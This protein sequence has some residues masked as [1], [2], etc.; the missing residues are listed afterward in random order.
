M[1]KNN[2][3]PIHNGLKTH[4]QGQFISPASLSPINRI[5]KAPV[6]PIPPVALVSF[7]IKS[8]HMKSKFISFRFVQKPPS[9]KE[10]KRERFCTLF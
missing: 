8:F 1:A 4:I 9:K 7:D 10:Y 5:V 2:A 6:N 3:N